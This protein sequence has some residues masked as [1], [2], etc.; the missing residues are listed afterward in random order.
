M[1]GGK[2]EGNDILLEKYKATYIKEIH[3][4]DSKEDNRSGIRVTHLNAFRVR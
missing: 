4:M 1:V 3:I 2:N